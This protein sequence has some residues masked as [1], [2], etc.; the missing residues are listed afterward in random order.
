MISDLSIAF[1]IALLLTFL[2]TSVLG[3]TG[4]GRAS[5]SGRARAGTRDGGAP[6]AA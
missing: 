5:V 2:F 3:T 6:A 1:G 4:P